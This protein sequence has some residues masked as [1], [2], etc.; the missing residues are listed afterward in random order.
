MTAIPNPEKITAEEYLRLTENAAE[1]TELRD[2]EI[3]AMAPPS[4]RHQQLSY[5]LHRVIDDHI[6]RHHG[7]CEVNEGI[8]V[9][10]DDHTLVIPDVSVVCDPEKL[11]DRYCHGA[12][13]WII[14][15]LSTNRSDDLIYK[16]A[17]YKKAGVREYW[18]VDPKN[19]KT[20]VYY[21]E[22]NDF[23]D[24]YTFDTAIPVE[25]YNRALDIRIAD[26]V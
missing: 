24:I 22:K 6:T 19:E 10:L 11:D 9:R 15:I 16:L 17:L 5:G 13:D 7:S 3:I 21:F 18:I 23:P 12:P 25:I 1:R 14:E 26:L 2:G 4:R 20:L 8:G